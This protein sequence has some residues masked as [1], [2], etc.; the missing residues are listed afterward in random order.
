LLYAVVLLDAV[1]I[2]ALW[3][4]QSRDFNRLAYRIVDSGREILEFPGR[5][6]GDNAF[7]TFRID[8]MQIGPRLM[9]CIGEAPHP[10]QWLVVLSGH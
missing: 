5:P 10:P 3:L 1:R 7:S 2:E 6:S 8:P 9:T 4:I